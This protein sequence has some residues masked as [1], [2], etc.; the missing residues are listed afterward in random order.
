MKNPALFAAEIGRERITY[1]SEITLRDLAAM[2]TLA[3][4]YADALCAA[5]ENKEEK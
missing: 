1:F 3:Y 5:R 4:I 2:A